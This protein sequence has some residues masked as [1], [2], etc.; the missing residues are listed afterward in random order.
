[1]ARRWLRLRA[2]LG[3]AVAS[4]AG[5]P[6]LGGG[7]ACGLAVTR[8]RHGMRARRGSAAAFACGLP[9]RRRARCT[10]PIQL[11]SRTPLSPRLYLM[12]AVQLRAVAGPSPLRRRRLGPHVTVRRLNRRSA[13]PMYETRHVRAACAAAI[14]QTRKVTRDER[15]GR[16][17]S[18]VTM[19][20]PVRRAPRTHRKRERAHCEQRNMVV[21]RERAHCEQRSMGPPA[22]KGSLRFR[23]TLLHARKGALQATQHTPSRAKGVTASSATHSFTRERGHCKQRNTLLHARKGSLQAAQHTPSRAKG[24]TASSAT[25]SFTRER[26]CCDFAAQGFGAYGERCNI[27]IHTSCP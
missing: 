13:R 6:W 2:R 26:G 18:S 20:K 12:S 25:H 11:T 1:L 16:R 14:S 24:V 4:L 8:R 9:H 23:S 5:S 22:R 10:A 3:S 7:F 19:E 27:C 15:A 17:R 21:P